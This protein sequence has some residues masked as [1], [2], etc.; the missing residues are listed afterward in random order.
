MIRFWCLMPKGEKLR[1]KQSKWIS[2]H[3]RILKIVELELL[4][5]QNTLNVKIWSLVGECL[6]MGKR[7]SFWLLIIFSLGLSLF[8]PKQVCLT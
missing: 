4:I 7:G 5:C 2:Y 6:I 1:P 3:L 8:V